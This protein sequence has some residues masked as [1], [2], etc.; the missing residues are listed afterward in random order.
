[1]GRYLLK[2]DY[3]ASWWKEMWREALPCGNGEFGASVYGAVR[4]ETIMLTHSRLWWGAITQPLPN[5]SD[6]LEKTREL[7]LANKPFEADRVLADR[8]AEL[9][10][11]PKI[12]SPLPL[13]DLI[14]ETTTKTAFT[15]YE[16][17]LDM[18]SAEAVVTWSDHDMKYKRRVF[19][20]RPDNVVA[21]NM[22]DEKNK[23]FNQEIS[24]DYHDLSDVPSKVVDLE[25][26]LPT[27]LENGYSDGYWTFCAKKSDGES[28]GCVA[29]LITVGAEPVVKNEKVVLEGVTEVTVLIKLFVGD[30]KQVQGLKAEL[31]EIVDNYETL[32]ERNRAEHGGMLKSATLDLCADTQ[33][34]SNE[35]LLLGAYKDRMSTEMIEKMWMY[36]RYLLIC[37]SKDNGLPCHLY[38]LWCGSY[39]GF[40]A[41]NMANENLQMIY[42]QALTGNMPKL[43]MAVFDYIDTMMDDFRLNAQ[44]LFGCRGIYIPAP[45]T[46][47]CGLIKI[48]TPHIIH[49]TAAAGWIAQ[50]YYDYYL[51]TQDEDFLRDRAI[52][53]MQEV[54][55]FYEDFL[56]EDK[57]GYLMAI[58]SNSPENT[59]GNYW[60]G[61]E[62]MG[63]V[64]ETTINSTIDI[65]V[66]KELLTNL[67]EASKIC[68]TNKEKVA[69]WYDM[70]CRLPKYQTNEDGAMKEWLHDFYQDNYR[71]R[72][73]SHIYP[74]FP[75]NEIHEETH[76]ELYK[77][78]VTAIDKRL[79]IGLNQQSGWSL[80]HMSN[81][82]AR[83]KEGNLALECLNHMAKSC[84]VSNFFTLHNDWRNMG[85][86][87]ETPLQAPVQLDANMGFCAAINEMLLQSFDDK[88]LILPALPD[89]FVK[90]E[91]KNL[92]ARGNVSVSICWDTEENVGTAKLISNKRDF[93]LEIIFP[94]NA[95]KQEGKHSERLHLP[96]GEEIIVDFLLK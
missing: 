86:G 96:K 58:P 84:V 8:F 49:F 37:S 10:Y 28:Y 82:Y 63:S 32:L 44:M 59:P 25:G 69:L 12:A 38:G 93:N 50:H 41:F 20:S 66:I 83:M 78:C 72:H 91:V 76:P 46:P 90:G 36:G 24:F 11:S 31:S 18:E 95:I 16:R 15:D 17:Y 2:N 77:A 65:A 64:M 26:Y 14:V 68:D 6:R 34:S 70:L 89:Y 9:G 62:G 13:C 33:T 5:V 47:D 48:V 53:F 43:M 21:F 80:A 75:G 52:P 60:D 67:I 73:Q 35:M 94:N 55:L 27:I 54:A 61:R 1:M 57:N 22:K 45:S 29:R 42:W 7:L 87:V 81:V 56:I 71:H 51:F 40:W 74:L 19:V 39:R 85:I 79:I 23:E 30:I 88:I 3:P 4:R 92:L